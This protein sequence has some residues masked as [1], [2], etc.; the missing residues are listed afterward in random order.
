MIVFGHKV[1][2]KNSKS[3]WKVEEKYEFEKDLKVGFLLAMTFALKAFPE[4]P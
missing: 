3:T 4:G 2:K 1:S